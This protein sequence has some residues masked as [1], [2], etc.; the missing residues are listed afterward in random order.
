MGQAKL[1]QQTQAA[2]AA[3]PKDRI[4][5]AIRAAADIGG[6]YAGTC[7]HQA[8]IG[9]R[10]LKRYG[11]DA[12]LVAGDFR[13]PLGN[14]YQHT[15]TREDDRISVRSGAFHAWLFCP[16]TQE[17]ID[18]AAWEAPARMEAEAG[19]PWP[20]PRPTYLWA[21]EATLRRQ[22]FAVRPDADATA[23][24]RRWMA[25][26]SERAALDRREAAV[27]SRFG[28]AAFVAAGE[29]RAIAA[30]EEPA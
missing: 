3:I 12:T 13:R 19:T 6:G 1:R 21:T 25:W 16:A 30:L 27:F 7:L 22:G 20:G 10:V 8:V 4:A 9:R 2:V 24:V 26:A 29:A 23:T 15:Y 5:D 14:G 11:L 18:F 28:D 17:V